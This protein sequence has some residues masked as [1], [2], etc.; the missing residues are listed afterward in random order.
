MATKQSAT[1]QTEGRSVSKSDQGSKL[2]VALRKTTLRRKGPDVVGVISAAEL[3][4]RYEIPRRDF[5]KKQG[6]QREVSKARVN[7]LA[8]DLRKNRVDLPTAVLLNIRD[9]D[10]KTDLLHE[11]DSYF[12]QTNG[13]PLYVVDGQHRIEALARLVDE[14]PEEWG[15]FQVA[16]TCMLG[17][18]EN[19]EMEEFYVVNSTAKSVRTDLALDLLKQRAE[20]DPRIMEGLLERGETWKVEGQSLAEELAKTSAW[21]GRIRFPGEPKGQTTIG[22]NGIVSSLRLPLSNSYFGAITRK[23][24]VEILEAYWKA[25]LSILP[26]AANEPTTFG[27]QKT[28]GVYVMHKVFITVL[29]YLRSVG[30]SLLDPESYAEL[31]RGPLLEL[32]GDTTEGGVARGSDFWR[33][34]PE[35][36]AGGFSSNAGQRVLAARIKHQLPAPVVE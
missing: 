16:F 15:A 27:L 20:N 32:E 9:F 29:E 34:A 14:D 36:A 19:E 26:E 17:A 21:H 30:K 13:K 5:R 33:G 8:A 12:L 31:L 1:P 4:M 28:I 10:A 18:T 11:G 25:I 23:N 24:R 3:V 22:S 6:Y 2:P 35:G 7:R